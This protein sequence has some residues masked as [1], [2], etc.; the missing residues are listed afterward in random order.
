MSQDSKTSRRSTKR[1]SR[2]RIEDIKP[3]C[4]HDPETWMDMGRGANPEGQILTCNICNIID[5]FQ[6]HEIVSLSPL[7]VS[8]P[9]RKK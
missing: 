6:D 8:R 5:K 2:K 4:P 9:M 3:E 7:R 1:P